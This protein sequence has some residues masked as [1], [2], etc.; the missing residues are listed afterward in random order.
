M[1]PVLCALA[2]RP[3]VVS[4]LCTTGQHRA[5]LD[6]SLRLFGLDPAYR[7][8]ARRRKDEPLATGLVRQLSP[9]VARMRPDWILAA[10]DTSS[11]LAAS[12]AALHHGVR[13]AHIEAGLRTHRKWEPFPEESYRRMA[14]VLA[15]LHL[16]PTAHARRNLRRE[17]VPARAIAV[18]GNPIIDTLQRFGRGPAPRVLRPL[19]R[20]LGLAAAPRR[21]EPRLIVATFHRRENHGAPIAAV[22]AAL[23]A[24]AEQ[25][26]GRV[27]ILCIVHPNPAVRTPVRQ[28]LHGVPHI[29]LSRSLDYPAFIAVLRRAALVLTDSGGLQE[30]AAHLGVPVLV[31]RRTTERPEGLA[32]GAA[33]LVGTGRG[34]IVRA[35]N[36]LL[37]DA[38]L[39]ARMAGGFRGYGDGRAA[40]RI[41]RAIEQHHSR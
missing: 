36:R 39:R 34:A 22:C 13:F 2:R 32:A 35:V 20:G 30:E 18:T 23:R 26:A 24:L 38:R 21:G 4:A 31:L 11:V 1:G 10:G 41:V 16:A 27:K 5:L 12:L 14:G 19:W 15:D 37:A 7:L 28:A 40:A 33:R 17:N 8:Q 9:V 6:Q 3:G 29:A 25:H